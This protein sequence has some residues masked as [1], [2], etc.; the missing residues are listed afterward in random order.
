[1]HN[2]NNNTNTNMNN[3][4]GPLIGM[5]GNSIRIEALE[6]STDEADISSLFNGDESGHNYLFRD[7]E[8]TEFSESVTPTTIR[9]KE[10]ATLSGHSGK[11][12][13]CDFSADGKFLASGGPDK[14]VLLWD[15]P[16]KSLLSSQ[17]GHSNI[18]SDVRFGP[19]SI[20][21]SAS[22]TLMASGSYDKTIRIW[23]T[24]EMEDQSPP[25]VFT[26][27]GHSAGVCS[28]DFHPSNFES[29]CS[30][31]QEGDLRFWSLTTGAT[32]NIQKK[33]SKIARFQPVHG[34]IL[35]T[36][37]DNE[38]KL[39]DTATQQATRTLTAHSARVHSIAWHPQATTLVTGSDDCVAVWDFA[40]TSHP[41]RT[42]K[43]SNISSCGFHPTQRNVVII[44]TYQ[45]VFLWDFEN[46]KSVAISAHEGIVSAIASSFASGTFATASHDTKIKL[47]C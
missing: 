45:R 16:K 36:G 29:L 1:M 42:F 17:P 20:T 14:K 30:V 9:Y 40:N 6:N 34:R 3:G 5:T 31:D 22:S 8:P 39:F 28:I 26:L 33:V 38:V 32:V 46:E 27:P 47:F 25:C 10:M 13:C 21:G 11:V 35:A 24:W 2:I 44:G 15:V 43:S 7:D 4:N 37:H 12:H 19:A 41:Q 23:K 18:I